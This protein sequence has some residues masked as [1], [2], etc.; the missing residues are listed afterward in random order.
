M[1]AQFT[2]PEPSRIPRD[3]VAYLDLKK[4]FGQNNQGGVHAFYKQTEVYKKPI[5]AMTF[6]AAKQTRC[7]PILLDFMNELDEHIQTFQCRPQDSDFS[8]AIRSILPSLIPL[9]CT[10]YNN[11]NTI[12]RRMSGGLVEDSGIINRLGTPPKNNHHYYSHP[13]DFPTLEE[14]HGL[15]T[16]IGSASSPYFNF[17][18]VTYATPLSG[19]P[20]RRGIL[21][22]IAQLLRPTDPSR[23][24]LLA[25]V[26]SQIF[27]HSIT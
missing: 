24:I 2:S 16:V 26:S 18:T 15:A 6:A 22:N 12:E 23:H 14:K 20:L 17:F 8:K 13:V 25:Q 9:A 5:L 27:A 1:E 4:I 3:D 7:L 21:A 19:P 10:D 11:A